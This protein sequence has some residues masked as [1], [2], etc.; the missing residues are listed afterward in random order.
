ML[1][2]V[3]AAHAVARK[4]N[5]VF[6]FGVG[7]AGGKGHAAAKHLI[8]VG[9]SALQGHHVRPPVHYALV[10]A[11]KAVPAQIHTVALIAY[12]LGNTADSLAFFQN[13][14]VIA[15]LEQFVGGGEA[16]RACANNVHLL[17]KRFLLACY[18]VCGKVSNGVCHASFF[19]SEDSIP[20]FERIGKYGERRM[21]AL[22]RPLKMLKIIKVIQNE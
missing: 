18:L 3:D 19:Y 7:A 16:G 8:V 2:I 12:R 14:Y 17:H 21:G 13:R 1:V 11:E 15:V 20:C 22:Q 6:L 9:G 5:A 4:H 10:L